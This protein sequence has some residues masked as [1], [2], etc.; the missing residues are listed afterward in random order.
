MSLSRKG[1]ISELTNN[2]NNNTDEV[3]QMLEI[4]QQF[5]A[6]G[7]ENK[8]LD[9]LFAKALELESISEEGYTGARAN[10]NILQ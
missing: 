2:N 7:A 3:W 10:I 1:A 6:K 8:V 9:E 5:E 4:L